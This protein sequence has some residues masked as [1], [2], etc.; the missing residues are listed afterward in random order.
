[1]SATLPTCANIISGQI[2][3][4][5]IENCRQPQAD[6]RKQNQQD[7]RRLLQPHCQ[8]TGDAKVAGRPRVSL[9]ACIWSLFSLPSLMFFP[10]PLAN[11]IRSLGTGDAGLAVNPCVL[12]AGSKI[13]ATA[14][15]GTRRDC[16]WE[17]CLEATFFGTNTR[18][19][20][21]SAF[22]PQ[23]YCAFT[24]HGFA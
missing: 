21:I 18:R 22:A 1:M 19:P 7:H 2:Q 6:R 8:G 17:P 23:H 13:Q 4:I 15:P 5:A 12:P 14:H 24:A 16:I 10:Y 3:S 20:R 11:P 9:H